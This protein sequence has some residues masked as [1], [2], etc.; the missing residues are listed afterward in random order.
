[1]R[2]VRSD[3]GRTQRLT[4]RLSAHSLRYALRSLGPGLLPATIP[5]KEVAEALR[6]AGMVT[7]RA[8]ARPGWWMRMAR[9]APDCV[10]IGPNGPT[11][12]SRVVMR[13]CPR[14]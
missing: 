6:R 10:Q 3:L 4:L 7:G 12:L 2:F 1:M 14:Q 8:D 5:G 13:N 11:S 9:T